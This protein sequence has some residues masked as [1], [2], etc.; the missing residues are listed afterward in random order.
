[1][2]K[3]LAMLLASSMVFAFAACGDVTET[4][5]GSADPVETTTSSTPAETTTGTTT[6]VVPADTKTSLEL[7]NEIFA[8]YLADTSIDEM[9]KLPSVSC[10][11]PIAAEK[12]LELYNAKME[13]LLAKPEEEVT[14]DDWMALNALLEGAGELTLTDDNAGYLEGIGFPVSNMG[15]VSNAATAANGR[16]ANFFTVTVNKITDSAN[17]QAFVDSY[18]ASM[19]ATNFVCGQPDA[20]TIITCG[21]YVISVFGLEDVINPF[22]GVI[23]SNFNGTVAASG[24]F[25]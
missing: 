2:K 18:K 20:Y 16:M 9:S 22:A 19:A 17:V 15:M 12:R 24:T 10:T 23:T 25:Y 7:F 8:A 14:E 11:D 5:T 13:E 3:I 4:T 21:D 6:P 1:M